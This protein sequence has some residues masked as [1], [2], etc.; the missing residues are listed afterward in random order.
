[1]ANPLW[2]ESGGTAEG[3]RNEASDL[4][5]I[6]VAFDCDV[7]EMAPKDRDFVEKM[8]D[9]EEQPISPRQLFWLRDIKDRYL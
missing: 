8:L 4:L 7:G 2:K 6:L 9:D 5:K 3:R 1:M